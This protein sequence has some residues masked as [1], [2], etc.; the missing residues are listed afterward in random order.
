MPPRLT[1]MPRSK[2]ASA[3]P[4]TTAARWNTE[5]VSGAIACAANFG[6]EMSPARVARRGSS[7]SSAGKAWSTSVRRAIFSAASVPRA[8]RAFAS[9]KPMKPPPPVMTIFMSGAILEELP[10]QPQHDLGNVGAHD[11]RG[12]KRHEARQYR[13]GSAFDGEPGGARQHEQHRA[14]R[15][16]QEANHE[17]EH[18]HQAE[19]NE[20]D[21]EG[22][23]DRHED[24]HEQ[25][26]R[27][28]RLEE[29]P[30]EEHQEVR[31]QQEHPGRVSE[32]KDP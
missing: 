30:D 20:V 3:A 4:E 12:E 1:R 11:E 14:E 10:R 18:H 6:S 16:V 32:R 8:S 28:H 7:G 27:R 13:H 26:D 19:V 17:I 15:R 9:L 21:A 22:L 5:V 29:T 23:A 31:E 24:G 2:S 25:R